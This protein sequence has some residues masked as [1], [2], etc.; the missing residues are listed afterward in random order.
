ME[1]G[2]VWASV[3]QGAWRRWKRVKRDR[4]ARPYHYRTAGQYTSLA[5]IIADAK[6]LLHVSE[7]TTVQLRLQKIQYL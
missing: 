7:L 6:G 2:I 5:F 3:E 1:I 4:T